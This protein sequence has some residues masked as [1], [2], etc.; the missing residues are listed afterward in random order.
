MGKVNAFAGELSHKRLKLHQIVR[1]EDSVVHPE[2]PSEKLNLRGGVMV[3]FWNP[4][5]IPL[6][7]RHEL[8]EGWLG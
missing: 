5:S 6:E 2:I 1:S 8:G 7:A 4:I 3:N